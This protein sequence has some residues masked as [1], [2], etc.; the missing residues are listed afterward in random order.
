MAGGRATQDPPATSPTCLKIFHHFSAFWLYQRVCLTISPVLD[1]FPVGQ[2]L[3]VLPFCPLARGFDP[4]SNLDFPVSLI[5]LL[6]LIRG[7]E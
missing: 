3:T 6:L 4:Y 7:Q 1:V 5:L 2:W